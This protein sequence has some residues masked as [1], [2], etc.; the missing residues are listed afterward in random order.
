MPQMNDQE[1]TPENDLMEME[2]KSLPDT[3][4]K[5]SIIRIIKG[6]SKNLNIL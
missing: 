3:E 2:A 4:L 1:K 5:T 6:F